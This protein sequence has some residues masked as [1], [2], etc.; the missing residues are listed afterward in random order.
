MELYTLL[1]LKN[2]HLANNFLLRTDD[3]VHFLFVR[4]LCCGIEMFPSLI[5]NR[6]YRIELVIARKWWSFDQ[7]F[8]A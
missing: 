4:N 7:T 6:V 3:I 1:I 8:N 2:S 5:S